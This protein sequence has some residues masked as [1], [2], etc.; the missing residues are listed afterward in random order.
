[1]SQTNIN[2]VSVENERRNYLISTNPVAGLKAMSVGEV[3]EILTTL[4]IEVVRRIKTLE[5]LGI[6]DD[7][8]IIVAKIEPERVELLKKTMPPGMIITEDQTL[9]YSQKVIFPS[10]KTL[11][12]T[13]EVYTK[14]FQFQILGEDDNPLENASVQIAG[15][16]F[17]IEGT[18]NA[19]GEVEIEIKMLSD[20][21][22]RYLRVAF[23]NNYWDVF[24]KNPNL[25]DGVNQIRMRSLSET[26]KGFPKDFNFGWGQRLMGLDQLSREKRSGAGVK[27]AIIDSG[28][29]TKHPLLKHIKFGQDFTGNPDVNSWNTDL[30]GHGTHCAG[31]IAASSTENMSLNGFAPDAEVHILRIFPGG[32]YSSLIEALNY[33]IEHKID[34]VN[35]SLGGDS[36]I[37]PIVEQK[38]ELAVNNG[39]ACITAAGNAGGAVF[40]PASSPNTLAVAA[41]GS[42]KE[43]QFNT[44]DATTMQT[45]LVAADG[46]FLPSFTCFGPE[47]GVCAPGVG[48]ISTAPGG[49]FKPDSGTS[50]AAP[51]IS[52]LAAILLAHHP[53]FQTQYRERG[54]ERVQALFNLIRSHCVL[55]SFQS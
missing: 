29:D 6:S 17:P 41:V 35:M 32:E 9:D 26:F 55:H 21:L 51:H 54:R 13:T 44:W 53:I 43:L 31:I 42:S 19:K 52:G 24:L 38:L 12:A 27:I 33:C 20:R 40:Y 47:V 3:H 48:I 25:S 39:V 4:G 49:F 22:P 11:S 37:N 50:M 18:T 14:K 10:I 36:K 46:I 8:S 34:V 7:K 45:G 23:P 2:I 5:T 28:C 15:D 30:I 16:A 1:M